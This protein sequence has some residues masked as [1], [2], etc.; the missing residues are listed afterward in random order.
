MMTIKETDETMTGK[1]ANSLK[2]I[3][4]GLTVAAA[5][6]VAGTAQ[7]DDA[8]VD[9]GLHKKWQAHSY[10]EA[11][12]KVC[13][14]WSQPTK[15]EEG[16]K[17]RGEIYAFVTHRTSSKRF[18]EVSFDMGYPLKD[19][20]EVTVSIGSKKFKLFTHGSSA[21]SF[22][23]KDKDLVNAMR[24]GI[25]MVVRGTSARGTK[26]RDVYSLKGFTNAHRAINKACK[27]S[28]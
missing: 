2:S 3:G 25:T 9:L 18:H 23:D 24:R 27:A 7:A 14:M 19:K 10:N 26:T 4:Q 16:G 6:F 20:S 28:F 12:A 8:N 5:I 11:G 1:R 17:P 15:H 13:N 22:K 21:F